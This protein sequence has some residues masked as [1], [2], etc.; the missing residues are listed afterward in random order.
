VLQQAGLD[1]TAS[2]E[3]LRRA[4]DSVASR[5][6]APA[7][8]WVASGVDDLLV[9]PP[10]GPVPAFC[11]QLAG[12][13]RAGATRLGRARL[14]LEPA[15]SHA[16]HCWATAVFGALLSPSFGADPAVT[17]V[18]G[19]AHHLYNAVLPDA[20][21]A[22]E[23]LLG[24]Q[25][26]QLMARLTANELATLPG[27]V[28]AAVEAALACTRAL[29][30]PEARVFQAADVLDRVLQ[31]RYHARAAAFTAAV[32]LDDLGLVHEGPFSDWHHEVLTA[33]E[34]LPASGARA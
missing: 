32:A 27:R 7:R 18:A 19:L 11:A 24:A 16:D 2:R 10:P 8:E 33:A 22:S 23:M 13:P 1:P 28:A 3:V 25:L 26:G 6:D 29:D 17:F 9:P 20:G 14:I 15:E 30:S 12:Q 4:V 31:A 5:L 34:L 21:F